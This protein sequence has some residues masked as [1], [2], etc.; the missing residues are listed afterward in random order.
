MSHVL[1]LKDISVSNINLVTL[2]VLIL[3]SLEITVYYFVLPQSILPSFLTFQTPQE[4]LL[5]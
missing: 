5:F 3:V 2:S 1:C 4:L